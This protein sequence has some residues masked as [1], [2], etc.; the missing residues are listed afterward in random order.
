MLVA[1]PSL[2][3]LSI[4]MPPATE[5]SNSKLTLLSSASFPKWSPCFEISAL[6][7]V[8]TCIL[9]FKAVSTTFFDMPSDN[10]MA[11]NKISTLTLLKISIGSL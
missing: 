1:S 4:G 6:L 5:A 3:V 11:S 2:I 8:I 7:G 10:P 9:F